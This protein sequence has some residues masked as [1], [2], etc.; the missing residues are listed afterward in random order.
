MNSQVS[1]TDEPVVEPVS[2]CIYPSQK[3]ADNFFSERR[4]FTVEVTRRGDNSFAVC[5]QDEVYGR[6]GTWSYEPLPSSREDEWLANY[7]WTLEEALEQAKKVVKEI[8]FMGMTADEALRLSQ[9]TDPDERNALRKSF[10]N[11]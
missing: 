4:F 3:I 6:D 7:R 5:V 1:G 11:Q 9:T 10:A 2:Y 8:V